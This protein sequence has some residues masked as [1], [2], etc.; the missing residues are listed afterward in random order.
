MRVLTKKKKRQ[1]KIKEKWLNDRARTMLHKIMG[2]LGKNAGNWGH[3]TIFF[4]LSPNFI[5]MRGKKYHKEQ[6]FI[7]LWETWEKMQALGDIILYFSPKPSIFICHTKK[8]TK[9]QLGENI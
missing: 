7:N 1:G 3:N 2:N 4:P 6:C 9:I 5:L 8:S